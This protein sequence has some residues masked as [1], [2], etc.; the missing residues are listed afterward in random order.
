MNDCF[1]GRG[2]VEK[3]HYHCQNHKQQK[4]YSLCGR[5]LREPKFVPMMIPYCFALNPNGQ[6][7]KLNH[8]ICLLVQRLLCGKYCHQLGICRCG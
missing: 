8:E 1:H 6:A 3:H 2:L 5:T 4:E 7:T